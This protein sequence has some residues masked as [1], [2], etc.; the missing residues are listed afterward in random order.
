MSVI[1]ADD[2]RGAIFFHADNSSLQPP[3]VSDISWSLQDGGQ[4]K[5]VNEYPVYAIPGML[6]NFLLNQLAQ[7]SGNMSEVPFGKE[8]V[9]MY[10]PH[11]TVRLYAK[12]DVSSTTG[13]PSLWVFLIIVLAILLSVVL[14]T[15]VVMHLI[16]RRQR[17]MLE[18]RVANGQVDLE[19]L[20]IKRIQ[21]PQ[22]LLDQ[23][24][25]YTWTAQREPDDISEGGSNKTAEPLA[26]DVAKSATDKL[27]MSHMEDA[28]SAIA[29]AV[30]LPARQAAFSQS[31][32]PICLDDFDSGET[33]VR[34]LPCNHIF[35][36]DCIDPFLRDNSSLCPLCKKSSL[37][38][39]YCPVH[40][41]NLM[42]RRERLMRRMA[43]QGGL[44]G[45]TPASRSS[46]T[47]VPAGAARIRSGR[48][49]SIP[50]VTSR[51]SCPYTGRAG[52]KDRQYTTK[53]HASCSQAEHRWRRST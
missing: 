21:V 49:I 27:S 26:G 34:E 50:T 16:Q 32:C 6:G 53:L 22:E 20:G 30:Q 18:R 12:M 47:A 35:H 7:Y 31:T 33:T 3:P 4:W 24:P 41:T 1:R 52:G 43:Q 2:A 46:R 8:L 17:R 48:G 15:S 5:S 23:M 38:N 25:Q 39:G 36:P 10:N 19:S 51:H 44:R 11:D 42:V 45:L 40:I 14:M 37:P 13:I 9:T 29:P 28:E